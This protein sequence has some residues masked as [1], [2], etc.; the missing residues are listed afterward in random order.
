MRK[1]YEVCQVAYCCEEMLLALA[2]PFQSL[3]ACIK[4]FN[5]IQRKSIG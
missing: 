5:D 3:L 4:E 1:L 2:P